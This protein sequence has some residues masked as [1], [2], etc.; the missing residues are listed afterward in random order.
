MK[1]PLGRNQLLPLRVSRRRGAARAVAPGMLPLDPSRAVRQG[2]EIEARSASSYCDKPVRLRAARNMLPVIATIVM[3]RFF[4]RRQRASMSA[5]STNSLTPPTVLGPTNVV[6][7]GGVLPG[8][9]ARGSVA[10]RKVACRL[11]RGGHHDGTR[12]K[13]I[14]SRTGEGQPVAAPFN[15]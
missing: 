13:A 10:P 1:T 4:G 11:A 14:N 2:R 5:F 12:H 3:L 8:R 9:A 15:P 7:R 6:P